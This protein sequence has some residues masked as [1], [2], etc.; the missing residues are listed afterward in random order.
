VNIIGEGI[1]SRTVRDTAHFFADAERTRRRRPLPPVGLV[2]GP[3][4]R[5][6]RI[7]LVLDSVRPVPT[8]TETRAAVLATAERLEKSGHEIVEMAP[9]IGEEFADDFTLLWALLAF[10]VS[11]LGPRLVRDFDP[12]K[13]D[14]LTRGLAESYRRRRGETVGALRRLRA[15]AATYAQASAAYD[16]V[17]CPTLAHT[18]PELG[19]LSPNQPFEQLLT[20]LMDYVAF[21]PLNNASG[22]PAISLPLGVTANGLPIGVQFM[23]RHGDER[24]LLEVAFELEADQPFRRLGR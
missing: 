8:D 1:V 12:D 23:G 15:S 11:G 18:T 9:P 14:G 3:G 2:E 24:T 6:L 16:A 22:S 10:T 19:Y 13:L 17:L 7:G 4:S 20:R 21:T 5:R